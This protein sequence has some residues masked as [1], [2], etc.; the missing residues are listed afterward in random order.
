MNMPHQFTKISIFITDNRL[1]AILKQM[2]VAVVT[3]V[4][5][6]RISSQQPLHKSGNTT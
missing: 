2:T 1:I 3:S 4:E 5:S 6:D